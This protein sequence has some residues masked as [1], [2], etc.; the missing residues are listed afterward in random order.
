MAASQKA[1]WA[2]SP[3]SGISAGGGVGTGVGTGAG[4]GGVGSAER[5]A[6]QKSYDEAVREKA[7]LEKCYSEAAPRAEAIARRTLQKVMKK[8]GYLPQKG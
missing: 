7:Y 8:V 1:G 4:A 3:V 2:V 5:G 6:R